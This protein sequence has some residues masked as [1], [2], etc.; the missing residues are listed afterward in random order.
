VSAIAERDRVAAGTSRPP[1]RSRPIV[2]GTLS[3]RFDARAERF[4]V[5][6]ALE[7]AVDLLVTNVVRLKPCPFTMALLGPAA[8]TLPDEEDLEPVRATARRAAAV[9]IH[10]RLLRVT[11]SHPVRALLEIVEESDAGLLVFGPDAERMRP[12][13]LDRAVAELRA[14]TP[15]LLWIAPAPGTREGDGARA[16][17]TTV[18]GRAG[19]R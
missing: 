14:R 6:A 19:R 7:A 8:A 12:R 15:C 10:T 1:R 5:D 9:G 11:S 16:S 17:G 3:V 13:T 2:L 4:A 18:R